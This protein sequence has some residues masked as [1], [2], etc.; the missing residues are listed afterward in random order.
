M[1]K[2]S[3]T[4]NQRGCLE[5]KRCLEAQLSKE[6]ATDELSEWSEEMKKNNLLLLSENLSVEKTSELD[7]QPNSLRGMVGGE[8]G[9]RRRTRDVWFASPKN[10]RR[11]SEKSMI[12]AIFH[13]KTWCEF[14]TRAKSVASPHRSACPEDKTGEAL[15]M[16]T[17]FC[18]MGQRAHP[19][20]M[21]IMVVKED[22]VGEVN[23][24]GLEGKGV[25]TTGED[26]GQVAYIAVCVLTRAE[27]I[28][29]TRCIMKS[30][31][32]SVMEAI[33]SKFK[34]FWNGNILRMHGAIK[35]S[36]SNALVE[37]AIRC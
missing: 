31:Q 18:F 7:E 3:S 9:M 14:C 24:Q 32:E 37:R 35:S 21:P 25:N 2:R 22:S 26:R 20:L 5:T 23:V 12:L 4:R 27:N 15:M 11:H 30:D 6:C 33:R 8:S 36:S 29:Y 16:G 19:D 34:Q 1:T 13:E 17:D 10:Q 28:G